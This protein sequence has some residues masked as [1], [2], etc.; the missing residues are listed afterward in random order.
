MLKIREDVILYSIL[1]SLAVIALAV[2]LFI[3]NEKISNF[4]DKLSEFFEHLLRS[5]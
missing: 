2:S 4:F 3:K 5:I 1:I